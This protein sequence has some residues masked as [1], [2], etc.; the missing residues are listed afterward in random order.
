MQRACAQ[1]T[2]WSSARGSG[3][4]L[5]LPVHLCRLLQT[6]GLQIHGGCGPLTWLAPCA[7]IT[8]WFFGSCKMASRNFRHIRHYRRTIVR[9]RTSI[10]SRG[11]TTSVVKLVCPSPPF[12]C[13]ACPFKRSRWAR[14]QDLQGHAHGQHWSERQDQPRQISKRL[15]SIPQH[16]SPRCRFVPSTNDLW[17]THKGL[18]PHSARFI[19]TSQHL[20][21]NITG[22]EGECTPL[23][24][25][26]GSDGIRSNC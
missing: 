14:G 5:P 15:A 25:L 4:S 12:I 18:H 17:T 21:W 13:C 1:S 3:T 22:Q 23:I 10:H 7:A 20:D 19:N 16:T 26:L 9:W 8:R 2:T 6:Q 24:Y 11:D